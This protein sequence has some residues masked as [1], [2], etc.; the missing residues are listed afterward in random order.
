M[1]T[2]NFFAA[3]ELAPGCSEAEVKAAFRRLALQHHPDKGGQKE[4]FQLINNAYEVLS[5]S[6]QREAYE[7]VLGARGNTG[8][9]AR[10]SSDSASRDCQY[11]AKTDRNEKRDERR[12]AAEM[13]ANRRRKERTEEEVWR[14]YR[15]DSNKTKPQQHQP[16][17]SQSERQHRQEAEAE[18]RKAEIARRRREGEEK[19]QMRAQTN[20]EMRVV[21]QLRRMCKHPP[22][23]PGKHWEQFDD[24]GVL[25]WYYEGP[26]GKWFTYD[27]Q[28]L[29]SCED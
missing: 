1:E 2:T 28:I 22:P 5:D 20:Q 15:K 4:M 26:L 17:E 7:A 29:Q 10:K 27:G 12:Y 14:S 11:K 18:L 13:Q 8:C 24:E 3:L 21:A 25:W 19:A 9:T 6:R 23:P 16:K